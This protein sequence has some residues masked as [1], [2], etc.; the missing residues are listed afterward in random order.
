M[1][2]APLNLNILAQ[3]S[4]VEQ[5]FPISKSCIAEDSQMIDRGTSNNIDPPKK[6]LAAIIQTFRRPT[7]GKYLRILQMASRSDGITMNDVSE[8]L[9]SKPQNIH[10][11]LTRL[12]DREALKRVKRDRQTSTGQPIQEF[13]Y[14]LADGIS[15]DEIESLLKELGD[16]DSLDQLEIIE[17][18]SNKPQTEEQEMIKPTKQETFANSDRGLEPNQSIDPKQSDDWRKE[19]IQMRISKL[20]EF[21]PEW[22][23]EAQKAWFE[24]LDRVSS[25]NDR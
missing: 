2:P 3:Y 11:L 23:P 4:T 8:Y 7:R 20:P 19:I 1:R 21:N 15:P 9:E 5:L 17:P 24:A 14:Y 18:E 10:P 25:I 22:T 12:L 6:S 13:Y 16:D